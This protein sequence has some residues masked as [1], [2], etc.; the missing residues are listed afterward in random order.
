MLSLSSNPYDPFEQYDLWLKF[1]HGEGFDT[2]GL[3]ARLVSSSSD[4]SDADQELAEEQ[5]IDSI[6]QN[7]SFTGLYKKVKRRS[8]ST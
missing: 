4:I 8:V 2:A 3:F 1:D 6:L 7:P 5:A